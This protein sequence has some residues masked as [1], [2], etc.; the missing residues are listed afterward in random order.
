MKGKALGVALM[1]V[2]FAV[3]AIAGVSAQ[4]VT[5][6]EVEFDDDELSPSSS[7]A[8]A[9]YERNQDVEVKVHFTALSADEEVQ[10][11]VELTG[12]EDD[13]VRDTEYVDEIKAGESYVERLSLNLPW[14]MDQDYYTLRVYICPRSGDCVEESYT[15][16]V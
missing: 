6:D 4:I 3:F 14:D 2:V 9:N 13:N 10:I 7:T 16:D 11:E 15:L 8:I 12:Y 1:L 5:I